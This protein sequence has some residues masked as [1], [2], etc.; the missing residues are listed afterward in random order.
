MIA[1]R[2]R[3]ALVP[4]VLA[5]ATAILTLPS[6]ASAAQAG[7]AVKLSAPATFT[8][9]AKPA[10][11]E[12]VVSTD[13]GRQCQKVRWS[14]LLRVTDGAT[15]DD[16]KITR[17]EDDGEFPLQSQVN[18]DTARLT[19][20][21]FDPGQLCRGSTVTARYLVAFDSA[22]SQGRM[23]YEV[24]ALSARNVALSEATA[25]SRV[26]GTARTASPSPTETPT[27][28]PP[29]SESSDAAGAGGGDDAATDE[30][31][32]TA[33]APAVTPTD[34]APATAAASQAGVPSLLGPGLIVGALFVFIG[35]GILLRLRLR[36][37]AP[38]TPPMP[39]SFY[40]TYPTR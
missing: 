34:A 8:A 28:T 2:H 4:A 22:A 11:I 18:G 30:P 21:N 33:A 26:E 31:S 10:T 7:F 1:V 23:T 5:V 29:S 24:Q 32:E 12:A 19:D 35:V 3:A 40:P 27:A 15:F 6:P 17:I 16:L 38:A 39:T 13:T 20:V 14:M 37:R 25:T 36:T 9:G